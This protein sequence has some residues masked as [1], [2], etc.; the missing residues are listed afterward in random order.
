MGIS[1]VSPHEADP[2][3]N[4]C[5]NK[6][7]RTNPILGRLGG[8]WGGVCRKRASFA[9]GEAK[10]FKGIRTKAFAIRRS[11]NSNIKFAVMSQ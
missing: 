8:E 10:I 9:K 4:L 2:S 11:S 6:I 3:F 7:E 5:Q 1:P